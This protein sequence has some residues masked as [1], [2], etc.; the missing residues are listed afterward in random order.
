MK[1]YRQIVE[2]NIGRKLNPNEIIH[3]KDGNQHNDNVEN[4]QITSR[5]EH[6]KLPHLTAKDW[7]EL[8]TKLLK[9]DINITAI[10]LNDNLSEFFTE[11]QK[12]IIFRKV[13]KLFLS[14]TEKEYYSRTIKKKLVALANPNLSKIA[15]D[16]IYGF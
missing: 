11:R 2:K 1:D 3:H 6:N 7:E 16:I 10:K 5:L 8:I 13:Y 4:L 14:K 9:N 15:H 12:Q